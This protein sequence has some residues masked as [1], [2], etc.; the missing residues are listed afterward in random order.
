M[1]IKEQPSLI[2]ECWSLLCCYL[3]KPTSGEIYLNRFH[4]L[5]LVMTKTCFTSWKHAFEIWLL[6][7]VEGIQH[8]IL[9][10]MEWFQL[11]RISLYIACTCLGCSQTFRSLQRTLLKILFQ[12]INSSST[13]QKWKIELLAYLYLFFFLTSFIPVKICE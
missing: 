3:C 8:M 5:C 2:A 13:S 6:H 12:L 9:T 11:S 4:L 10:L 1:I 7:L